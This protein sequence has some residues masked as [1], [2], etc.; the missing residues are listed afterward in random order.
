M[1]STDVTC[2]AYDRM[3]CLPKLVQVVQSDDGAGLGLQN[4]VEQSFQADLMMETHQG[5]P[6][7]DLSFALGLFFC[8]VITMG[9]AVAFENHQQL[10]HK[11]IYAVLADLVVEA[12]IE[13]VED[14]RQ[15]LSPLDFVLG[16]RGGKNADLTEHPFFQFNAGFGVHA[17]A[18]LGH[19]TQL[20]AIEM[21]GF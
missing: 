12:Q 15:H 6:L 14:P 19:V 20:V 17:K 16:G 7:G 21:P 8:I 13:T 18:D 4:P 3:I 2:L 11:K 5:V 10:F 1:F 9:V